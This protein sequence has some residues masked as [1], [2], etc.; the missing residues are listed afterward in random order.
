MSESSGTLIEA[1]DVSMKGEL[2]SRREALPKSAVAD[3]SSGPLIED[4]DFPVKD[5]L[6]L[7]QVYHDNFIDNNCQHWRLGQIRLAF[8][9]RF[10]HLFLAIQTTRVVGPDDYQWTGDEPSQ[11]SFSAYLRDEFVASSAVSGV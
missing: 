8:G 5:I 9:H 4:A 6:M 2:E 11:P 1:A 7:E 10:H 3:E